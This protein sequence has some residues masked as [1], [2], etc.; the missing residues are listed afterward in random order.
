MHVCLCRQILLPEGF[1]ITKI[2]RKPV[3]KPSEVIALL[4]DNAEGVLLEGYYPGYSQKQYYGIGP[5]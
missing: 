1:I 3:T 5:R 4:R 2:N